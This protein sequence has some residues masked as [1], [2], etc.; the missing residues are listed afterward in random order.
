MVLL[1][2]QRKR[3]E[4]AAPIKELLHRA[5]KQPGGTIAI[6]GEPSNERGFFFAPWRLCARFLLFQPSRKGAKAQ[7]RT[8]NPRGFAGHHFSQLELSPIAPHT[9][10][11][12]VIPRS[13]GRLLHERSAN[14]C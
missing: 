11:M 10:F 4:A 7:R 6:A 8:P 1:P 5:G 12:R 13:L 2:G 14:P 9:Y 3:D